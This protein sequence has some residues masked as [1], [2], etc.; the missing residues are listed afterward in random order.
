MSVGSS[1]LCTVTPKV[2]ESLSSVMLESISITISGG[3]IVTILASICM[4]PA[5]TISSI[6]S[7]STPSKRLAI[8]IL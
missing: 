5:E 8:L 1:V 3:I 7:G 2:S 6:F 4:L